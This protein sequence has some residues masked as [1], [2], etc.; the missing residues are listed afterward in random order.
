M[1]FLKTGTSWVNLDL[2]TC[3]V[4]DGDTYIAYYIGGRTLNFSA[5]E[6]LKVISKFLDE[7]SMQD[8]VDLGE[9]R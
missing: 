5:P 6:E 3:F 4:R 1:K 8:V 9:S 2:V 7:N